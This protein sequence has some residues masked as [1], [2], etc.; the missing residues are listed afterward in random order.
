MNKMIKRKIAYF[1]TAAVVLSYF[2]LNGGYTSFADG[3]NDAGIDGNAVVALAESY[4]G[5]VPYVSGGNSLETGTD[6]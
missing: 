5:K 3:N 6:C 4:V 1:M 2:I